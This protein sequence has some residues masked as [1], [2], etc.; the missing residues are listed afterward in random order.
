MMV[1][2]PGSWDHVFTPLK[3]TA[4]HGCT[5]A[6]LVFPFFIW[7]IGV[8]MIF[9]FVSRIKR[10]E[11]RGQLLK[12]VIIRSVILFAI[13]IFLSGFPFGLIGDHNFSWATIRIPGVLQRIAI[14]YLIASL[15]VLYSSLLWQMIWL[16]LLLA[17]YCLLIKIVPVPGFGA[18]ILEPL[19]NLAWYL[20][21]NLLSGHTWLR[22]PAP[23]FDPEGILGTVPAIATMLFG[24]LTGHLLHLK[25]SAITKTNWMLVFGSVLIV[26]GLLLSYW[27]P[28]NKKLWTSSYAVF[29]SGV[30]LTFFACCYWLVDVKGYQ[31]WFKPW[32]IF[33]MNALA[34]YII[35]V[36]IILSSYRIKITALSKTPILLKT[37]YYQ[38]LFPVDK[39]PMLSSFLHA[40][41]FTLIMYLI[42]YILYRKR[43]II[44]V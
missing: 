18:G 42:A 17:G 3:H 25:K 27:L 30:A 6:D 22:A 7:I 37:Y 2:G 8:T 15:I 14:C 26:L 41:F 40:I 1:N 10:G 21:A 13:G 5:L 31:K 36:L 43:W 35:S 23:G 28:I 16:V 11:S 4:W 24:V 20:D 9:S 38:I 29:V 44:T 12:K 34:V 33:G 32:Q 39:Y 19:G